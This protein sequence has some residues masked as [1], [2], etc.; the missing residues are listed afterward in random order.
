MFHKVLAA[1]FPRFCVSCGQEGELLCW[2]CSVLWHHPAP[3]QASGHV[4]VYAYANP[5]ARQLICAWKY[6]YD[7]SALRILKT[8]AKEFLPRLHERIQGWGI[9]AIVPL[10]LSPQRFRERGFNQSR[11]LADWL[12]AE[13][14]LPVLELL[15]RIHRRGHQAERSDDERKLAMTDSPFLLKDG[16]RLPSTVLL[17]DDV[18]TTGAT[19]LAAKKIL[20]TDEKTRV[21]SF[22]LAQG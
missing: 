2:H 20:E 17:V 16:G 18:W 9:E 8:E 4:A 1:V 21:F 19:M 11:Q 3:E 13:L 6:E 10:P 14:D 5:I 12:A 7:Q 15:E 22:T